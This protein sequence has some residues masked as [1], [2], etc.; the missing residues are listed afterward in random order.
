MQ[1]D[2][3]DKDMLRDLILGE[4]QLTEM[5]TRAEAECANAGLREYLQQLQ[6]EVADLHHQAFHAA[7]KR[8]WYY[9]PTAGRNQ[10]EELIIRWEQR[11]EREAE[12][13]EAGR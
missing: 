10:I 9:T 2:L 5:A 7:H 11:P 4:K 12:L 1:V 13:R 8:G 6:A 3:N